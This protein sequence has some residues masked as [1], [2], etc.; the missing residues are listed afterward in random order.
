[1][2]KPL[3]KWWEAHKDNA[4]VP[5]RKVEVSRRLTKSAAAITADEWGH[6]ARQERMNKVSN[7][8]SD[9]TFSQNQKVL[10]INP[11]HPAIYDLLQ[12]VKADPELSEVEDTASLIAQ[13]A[14]LESN[15]DLE[16]P[17]RLVNSVF[18]LLMIKHNIDPNVDIQPVEIE[19]PEEK[20]EDDEEE[21]EENV[22]DVEEE[23]ES[24]DG[25]KAEL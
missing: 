8:G 3:T 17:E 1:M 24:V 25:E 4:G 5:I 16:D 11:D 13:A 2:Y 20:K 9:S 10:E 21:E 15:F 7:D 14:V 23:M 6:S 18:D 19:L 12:K 22:D